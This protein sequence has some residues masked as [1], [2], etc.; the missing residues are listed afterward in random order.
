MCQLHDTDVVAGNWLFLNKKTGKPP[1]LPVDSQSLTIP[2]IRGK[3]HDS[4][5]LKVQEKETSYVRRTKFEV[6]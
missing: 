4:E 3:S 1:A 5:P 6:G 2:G